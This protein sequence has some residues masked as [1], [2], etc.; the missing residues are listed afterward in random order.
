M[1]EDDI[2]ELIGRCSWMR[3]IDLN[4]HN[5]PSSSVLQLAVACT[6]LK[7]LSWLGEENPAIAEFSSFLEN[8][9]SSLESMELRAMI[10]AGPAMAAMTQRCSKLENIANF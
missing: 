9:P 8:C 3:E 4:R 6:Q 1:T 7:K 2:E 10:F 5:H